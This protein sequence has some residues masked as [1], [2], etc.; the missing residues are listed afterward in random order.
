MSFNRSRALTWARTII[1]SFAIGLSATAAQ[2]HAHL[3]KQTPA[4]GSKGTAPAEIQLKFSEGL[5][6]KFSAVALTSASGANEATGKL[7]L[8][9]A[10]NSVLI[11][12]IPGR[13]EPGVYTVNWRAVSIDT[14]KTQGSYSF[15][16]TP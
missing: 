16:V 8:D 1:V 3:Q 13:L 5:E 2:A 10:D 4:A 11:A 6:L 12:T 14:H 15:T 9:P 7:T